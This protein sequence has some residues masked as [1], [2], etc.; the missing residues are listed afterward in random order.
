MTEP[1]KPIA[2]LTTLKGVNSAAHRPAPPPSDDDIHELL[3]RA[4]VRLSRALDGD[5]E[6]AKEL[7]GAELQGGGVA[8]WI[9]T[10]SRGFAPVTN[11]FWPCTPGELQQRFSSSRASF[12]SGAS[13]G[14]DW[15]AKGWI[16]VSAARISSMVLEHQ[17]QQSSPYIY[18]WQRSRWPLHDALVWV[19]SGGRVT[20]TGEI[21]QKSLAE[22]GAS[23]LFE[24]LSEQPD[25][26]GVYVFGVGQLEPR[27]KMLP[28]DWD[29][30]YLNAQYEHSSAVHLWPRADRQTGEEYAAADFYQSPHSGATVRDLWIRRDELF[31][32]FPQFATEPKTTAETSQEGGIE[33]VGS[34]HSA[35]VLPAIKELVRLAEVEVGALV[36]QYNAGERKGELPK[37]WTAALSVAKRF[38]D[39]PQKPESIAKK[40]VRNYDKFAQK[41]APRRYVDS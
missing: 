33:P 16:F 6:K 23:L 7:L 1:K 22:K 17:R 37:L 34:G 10:K 11:G 24:A 15:A 36:E 18:P 39:A 12:F 25:I 4:I 8:S 31:S 40:I 26:G 9:Y 20:T 30:T 28:G 5:K 21:S 14:L 32:L 19:G 38:P 2:P 27:R 35:H 29:V 41:P 3:S 13:K